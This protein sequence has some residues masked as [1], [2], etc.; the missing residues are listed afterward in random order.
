LEKGGIGLKN[1]GSGMVETAL[2]RPH[3]RE[4]GK[5]HHLALSPAKGSSSAPKKED[6]R[7]KRIATCREGAL[8]GE[9][10]IFW[11]RG[12]ELAAIQLQNSQLG[13]L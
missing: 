10:E 13:I 4:C 12:G 2:R 9:L 3:Y 8:R 6:E 1:I 11:P 7:L 5:V